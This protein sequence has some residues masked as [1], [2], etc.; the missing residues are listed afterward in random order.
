MELKDERLKLGIAKLVETYKVMKKLDFSNVILDDIS[1]MIDD[2][3]GLVEDK[4]KNILLDIGIKYN[5][6]TK[7]YYVKGD[8]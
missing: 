2:L 1:E 3:M 7:K 5:T 4:D 8:E 6:E